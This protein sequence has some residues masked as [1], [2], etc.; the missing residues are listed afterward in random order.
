MLPGRGRSLKALQAFTR[1]RYTNWILHLS[2][3]KVRFLLTSLQSLVVKVKFTFGVYEGLEQLG[4]TDDPFCGCTIIDKDHE[5]S[6]TTAGLE[7]YFRLL[8]NGV[9]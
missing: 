1:A 6:I 2:R 4:I 8:Y 9:I 3:R 7:D 5:A